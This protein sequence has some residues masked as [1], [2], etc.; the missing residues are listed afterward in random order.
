MPVDEGLD[1]VLVDLLAVGV[2]V[3]AVLVAA[4]TPVHILAITTHN[5]LSAPFCTPRCLYLLCGDILHRLS[6]LCI[7]IRPSAYSQDC[8]ECKDS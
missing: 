8:K 1:V 4:S 3:E 7:H 2:D 6:T 5:I